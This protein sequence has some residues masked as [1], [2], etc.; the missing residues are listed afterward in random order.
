VIWRLNGCLKYSS[1]QRGLTA[2]IRIPRKHGTSWGGL[3]FTEERIGSIK[4]WLRKGNLYTLVW[5]AT[6]QCFLCSFRWCVDTEDNKK[7]TSSHRSSPKKVCFNVLTDFLVELFTFTMAYVGQDIAGK[8]VGENNTQQFSLHWPGDDISILLRVT[9]IA[10]PTIL[11]VVNAVIPGLPLP[12]WKIRKHWGC[13]EEPTADS[14]QHIWNGTPIIDNNEGAR[15]EKGTMKLHILWLV[16]IV[17]RSQHANG[18]SD[19]E[20]D[21]RGGCCYF[22]P[23]NVLPPPA[24]DII[25]D[26]GDESDDDAEMQC[27]NQTIIPTMKTGFQKFKSMV[28]RRISRQHQFVD[29][30]RYPVPS[31]CADY[32]L[33]A[34]VD[35]DVAWLHKYNHIVNPPTLDSLA[36]RKSMSN[37]LAAN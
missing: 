33:S 18:T 27:S 34:V 21:M 2:V 17:D 31:L 13:L 36:N 12:S 4:P 22:P 29:V 1:W 11:L 37:H 15:W 14:A 23:Y 26:I 8:W 25:Q 5:I 7:E 19:A 10:D 3:A 32:E 6:P 28:E 20:T 9:S 35:Q 24:H 30:I 16:G